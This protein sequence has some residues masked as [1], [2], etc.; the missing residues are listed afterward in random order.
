MT[1]TAKLFMRGRSRA[2]RLPDEFRFEGTEVQV[3]KVSD[4]VILE[5]IKKEPFDVEAWFAR[6]DEL[7]ARD[8]LPE[9]V[10]DEAPAEP[11]PPFSSTN[12][13]SRHEHCRFPREGARFSISLSLLLNLMDSPV[14]FR[15]LGKASEVSRI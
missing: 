6:L 8:V 2:V 4:K 7:G 14:A 15:P 3:G 12:D 9:S 13:L 5:P 1:S 11:T 10:P